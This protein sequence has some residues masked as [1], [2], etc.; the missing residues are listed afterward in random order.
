MKQH[1]KPK[2]KERR[3]LVKGLTPIDRSVEE[4]FVFD[5]T[6]PPKP[7]TPPAPVAPETRAETS[8]PAAMNRLPL[9]T[10]VR[11]DIGA[12]LKRASLERQLAG[13][14]P[15]AVQDILDAALEPW[16]RSNGYLG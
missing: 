3:S 15:N 4:A 16:L 1:S 13:I 2:H 11:G 10:R 7:R 12:A 8:K 14:E 9:T 6:N 5:Q